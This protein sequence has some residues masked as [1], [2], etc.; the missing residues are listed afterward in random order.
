[1]SAR[2]DFPK[3]RSALDPSSGLDHIDPGCADL[4]WN[5]MCDAIDQLSQRRPEVAMKNACRSTTTKDN[6]GF[7]FLRCEC[8]VEYGPFDSEDDARDAYGEH[9]V[10]MALPD[11]GRFY[12]VTDGE[13][14]S[15]LA[16]IDEPEK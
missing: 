7:V 14:R 13:Q 16:A 4:Q 10:A 2:D 3:W 1:M 5:Q 15:A 12:S 8:G 6:W 9:R 11:T